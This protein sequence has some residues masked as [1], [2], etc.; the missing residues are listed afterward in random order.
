MIRNVTSSLPIP[1]RTF[2][3]QTKQ[4][5]YQLTAK[6]SVI[7]ISNFIMHKVSVKAFETHI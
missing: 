6:L 2:S 7:H 1:T 3:A 5:N 4:P